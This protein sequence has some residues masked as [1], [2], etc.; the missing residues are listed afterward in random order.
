MRGGGVASHREVRLARTE[1][2]SNTEGAGG[3]EGLSRMPTLSSTSNTTRGSSPPK[4]CFKILNFDEETKLVRT[5]NSDPAQPLIFEP[6]DVIERQRTQKKPPMVPSLKLGGGASRNTLQASKSGQPTDIGGFFTTTFNLA[7]VFESPRGLAFS[8]LPVQDEEELS[9]PTIL[10]N[11]PRGEPR[12][13][14]EE[15]YIEEEDNSMENE[16]L[17]KLT[18]DMIFKLI[19][20]RANSRPSSF[21]L[22]PPGFAGEEQQQQHYKEPYEKIIDEMKEEYLLKD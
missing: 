6:V 9:G 4:G 20:S 15:E 18:E 10:Q 14:F 5:N 3:G 2:S 21:M 1:G 8:G 11:L 19:D 13:V 12:E 7:E 17:R 22:P 16:S